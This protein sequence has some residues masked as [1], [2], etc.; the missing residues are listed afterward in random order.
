[1]QNGKWVTMSRSE[2][3]SF[4]V[5]PLWD[6]VWEERCNLYQ[7]GEFAYCSQRIFEIQYWNPCIWLHFQ[8]TE[9]NPFSCCSHRRR[10][11]GTR[12]ASQVP[13]I[14]FVWEHDRRLPNILVA[15]A[16]CHLMACSVFFI[17]TAFRGNICTIYVV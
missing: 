5:E 10:N 11:W 3:G 14:I 2:S 4:R 7:N 15:I 8:L 17:F 13:S 16:N 1:M 9:D 6:W 12:D